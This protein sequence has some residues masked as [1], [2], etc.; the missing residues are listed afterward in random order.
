LPSEVA[1]LRTQI[2]AVFADF[3]RSVAT[4]RAVDAVPVA[5]LLELVGFSLQVAGVPEENVI[6]VFPSKSPDQS[7]NEGMRRGE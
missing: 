1:E 2:R 6:Q 7:L 5:K 3:G 4:K